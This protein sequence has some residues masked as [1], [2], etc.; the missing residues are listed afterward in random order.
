MQG[1]YQFSFSKPTAGLHHFASWCRIA[2]FAP[3]ASFCR[4][5]VEGVPR[6]F[7]AMHLICKECA[8]FKRTKKIIKNYRFWRSGRYREQGRKWEA[9][10]AAPAISF[11]RGLRGVPPRRAA[12]PRRRRRRRARRTKGG[13]LLCGTLKTSEFLQ[14][15]PTIC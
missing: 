15:L 6:K 1:L 14:N 10:P 13:R 5:G 12:R 4:I 8:R 9:F 7:A 3:F 11:S 2:S